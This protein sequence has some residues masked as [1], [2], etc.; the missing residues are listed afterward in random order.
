MPYRS[1][2]SFMM[3][4]ADVGQS[5]RVT[6]AVVQRERFSLT[7]ESLKSLY[8]N[9]SHTFDLVYIDAGSPR[10]IRRYLRKQ[11]RRERFRLI[12][13]Q[14]YLPPN[15]ARNIALATVRTP[16][17]VL[18]DNDVI[19]SPGWLDALVNC[20]ENTG[21]D[22]VTPLMCIGTPVH[23]RVHVAGGTITI[24]EVGSR[25]RL[26]EAQRF[27]GCPIAEVRSGLIREET[28][29]AEFHCILVRS[30][31]FDRIGALDERLLST[32]EH[33]DFSL[34]VRRH[35]G[36]IVFEPRALITYVPPPPLAL[37]DIPFYVLRWSDAWN[38]S[39]ETY[40]HSKWN[41]TFDDHVARFGAVHRRLALRRLRQ[42]FRIAGR[43]RAEAL[44]ER[45]D[46]I[47]IGRIPR[48]QNP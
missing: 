45:L 37:S 4:S 20:A 22:V 40:F 44:S 17:V 10:H 28:D 18:V 8:M 29:L 33:L 19:F 36:K 23:S 48:P 7:R 31:L 38:I 27:E 35:G 32:S 2:E 12:R 3:S 24:S 42:L 21:A 11:A 9:T 1:V 16:Y 46:A 41:L 14:Y 5:P 30:S 13:E 47:I 34:T 25:R 43:R 15:R 6:I 26:K 39:S